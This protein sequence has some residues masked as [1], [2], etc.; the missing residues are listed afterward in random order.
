MLLFAN[1]TSIQEGKTAPANDAVAN[2]AV[3]NNAV[4]GA[5]TINGKAENLSH[6]YARRMV[7]SSISSSGKLEYFALVFTN[8]PVPEDEMSKLL[9]NF[10]GNV[11]EQDFLKDKSI[12]GVV[13]IVHKGMASN[14]TV[15]YEG[16]VILDGRSYISRGSFNEFSMQKGRMRGK[17]SQADASGNEIKV[18][19]DKGEPFTYKYTV[20][21]EV[22]PQGEPIHKELEGAVSPDL[23]YLLSGPGRAEGTVTVDGKTVNLKYAYALRKREFFD[24][25]EEKLEVLATDKPV[26]KDVLLKFLYTGGYFTKEGKVQGVLLMISPHDDKRLDLMVLHQSA[27]DGYINANSAIEGLSITGQRVTAKVTDAGTQ[28]GKNWNYSVSVDLPFKR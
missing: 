15:R 2:N 14:I 11:G 23:P 28:S 24:E 12:S 17:T 7:W 25:P 5:V 10:A 4:S 22:T 3:A 13:F 9:K 16:Q 18:T 20:E 21:F 1:C 8:K 6:V 26:A 27:D 19:P